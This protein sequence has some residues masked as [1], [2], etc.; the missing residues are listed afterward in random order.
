MNVERIQKVNNLAIELMKKGLA[1]DRESAIAQAEKTFQ[2]QPGAEEYNNMRETL[3]A[4]NED[5]K[6]VEERAETEISQEKIK[7]ILEQNT[8]FLVK[9]IR[10]FQEKVDSLEREIESLKVRANFMKAAQGKGFVVEETVAPPPTAVEPTEEVSTIQEPVAQDPEQEGQSPSVQKG[11]PS[12]L[13]PTQAQSSEDKG[14]NDNVPDNH[15]RSGNYNE[16]DV[17]IEKFFYMGN[18][19]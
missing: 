1:P 9:T 4:I 13:E 2:N 3:N 10:E 16:E 6:P 19:K 12:L 5:R 7:E 17:S 8:T 18:G 11:K 14:I 15:P